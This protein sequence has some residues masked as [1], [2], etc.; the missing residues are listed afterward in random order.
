MLGEASQWKALEEN[1]ARMLS[2]IPKTP[3]TH[4]A[5]MALWRAL[6]DLYL[7]VLKN[8]GGRGGGLRRGG[9]GPAG[10]REGAG[11]LRRGGRRRCRARRRRPSRRSAGR[12]RT[13]RIRARCAASSC[14]CWRCA[15]T[16][17]GRGWPRRRWRGLIGDPGDDEKEILTKLGPYAKRKEVAQRALTDRLWQSHLFHPKVRRPLSEL[18]GI[19]FEQVGHLYA[20]P[21]QQYQ[22]VPK[23]HRIDVGTSQEYHVHHYRYVARLLRHG[24]GGAVLA[25]PRGHA[26]AAQPALQRAGSR[27]DDQRGAAAD[28]PGLRARGRQVLRGAGAERGLL[29][30]GPHARRWRVRSSPSASGWRRIGSRPCCRRRSACCAADPAARW[31]RAHFDGGAAAAGEEPQRACPGGAVPRWLRAYLPTAT[32]QDV[33]T[34]LEGVELTAARAGLFAAGEMEPVHRMVQRG[35]RL[36]LPRPVRAPSYGIYWCL[37]P[38]RTCMICVSP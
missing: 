27:A 15:R 37:R 35:D 22:I 33:R 9:Q 34:W 7:Q 17:T 12:C 38:P 32:P 2:R 26:R 11:D 36:G 18:M 25:V 29:P 10:R 24:G 13:R 16:T 31:I 28:A 3:D 4:V 23:K 14:G 21:F 8:T 19:L 1:Y 5:R 20:V 30:A 6:G